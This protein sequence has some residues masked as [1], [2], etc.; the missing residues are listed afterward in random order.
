MSEADGAAAVPPGDKATAG[1]RD[2]DAWTVMR[3]RMGVGV[4]GVLLPLALPAGN[5]IAARLD[6]RTGEGAW[7]GSMSGSYYTSTRDVFVGALC[8]LGIFLIVYR[9]NK[10]NDVMGTIAGVCA[11]GVALFPTAPGSGGDAGRQAISVL[12]QVFA[13]ALLTSMAAFCLLMYRAPGVRERSYVRRPYLVAGVLIL[14][15]M[16]L[17]GAA[18]ATEVGDDWLI[19]PL[20]LCEW[21]S[22]WSFGFAWTGAALSLAEDIDR[23][24]RTR[25]VVG[26]VLGWFRPVGGLG[27][28]GEPRS[29]EAL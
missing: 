11:L 29:R 14:A 25:A 16:A 3:L 2:Q 28:R 13:V 8:A 6:G 1:Q 12:H 5:W 15:F 9:Y 19:T 10:V 27:G 7:P 21:L 22:V 18:A 4:I 23:L 20:Y 24:P 26:A 17:A